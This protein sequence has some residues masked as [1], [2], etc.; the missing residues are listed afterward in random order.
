[1][2]LEV[3]YFPWTYKSLGSTYEN[4]NH[5]IHLSSLIFYSFEATP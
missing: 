5:D 1:M 4:D 3:L 2:W